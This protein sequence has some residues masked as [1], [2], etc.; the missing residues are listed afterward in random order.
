MWHYR[1]AG[2]VTALGSMGTVAV[3]TSWQH[4]H[5]RAASIVTRLEPVGTVLPVG[6]TG[7]TEL[8]GESLR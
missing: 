7:I 3:A 2:K 8:Q 6:N 1:A 5:Y 4:W